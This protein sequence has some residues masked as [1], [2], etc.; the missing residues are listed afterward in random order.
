MYVRLRPHFGQFLRS[1]AGRFEIVVFTASQEVYA[2]TLLHLLDPKG[3]LIE[4]RLFR[5]S[6]VNVGG[7]YVK[8]IA[9]LSA[10]AC[11][12]VSCIG[13]ADLSVLGRDLKRMVIVDNS[14]QTFGYQL[15]NG[16]PIESWFDDSADRYCCVCVTTS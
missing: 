14:P 8:G 5:D 9:S 11:G 1:V 6:C 2:D 3:E 10:G 15:D 4:H 13:A 12:G 16:I 7:N